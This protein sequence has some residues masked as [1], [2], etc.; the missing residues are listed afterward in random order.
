MKFYWMGKVLEFLG[1]SKFIFF[2]KIKIGEIKVYKIGKEYCILESEI[3]RFFEGKV[4]DK[5]V[6]YVRVLS[7]D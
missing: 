4:F 1:I 2:R 6:I 3:K 5:V 7:R